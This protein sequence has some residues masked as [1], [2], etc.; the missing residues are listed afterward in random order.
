[1]LPILLMVCGVRCS[2]ILRLDR[3]W[4]RI[5]QFADLHMGEDAG[6]DSM[7]IELM[8]AVLYREKPDFIVFTG[9]QVTGY[10]AV[11][12]VQR[13]V[14]WRKALSVAAEF[15]V[16]FATLFGNH[17]DQLYHL[18]LFMW[19]EMSYFIF[20]VEFCVCAAIFLF[21][22]KRRRLLWCVLVLSL[23]LVGVFILATTPSK[24]LRTALVGYE[25]QEYPAL[26]FT[27]IGPREVHGSSNYRVIL[28]MPT[29]SVPLYFVDSGGGMIDNAIHPDQLAWL[30]TFQPADFALAFVHVSPIP[31]GSAFSDKCEGDAPKEVPSACPGS[32]RLLETLFAIGVRGVFVGHDHGNSWCCESDAMLLCYGKHSGFGGYNFDEPLRGARVIEVNASSSN[33]L[34]RTRIALWGR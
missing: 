26:S 11:S 3:S 10:E 24:A 23:S 16:P 25:H 7:T 18:D 13:T 6:K 28:E 20:A 31:F 32:E 33:T 15:Q 34:V 5:V 22:G 14:L 19:N 1:M 2:G 12:F 29:A 8:R 27:K 30:H 21:M 9:D 17:D 4:A